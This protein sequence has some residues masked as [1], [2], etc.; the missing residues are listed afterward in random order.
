M[1]AT[2]IAAYFQRLIDRVAREMRA[3]R[4]ARAE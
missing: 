4:K 2:E 3:E 1:T